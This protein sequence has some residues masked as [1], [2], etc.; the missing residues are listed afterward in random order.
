MNKTDKARKVLTKEREEYLKDMKWLRRE[1]GL[2]PEPQPYVLKTTLLA[3]LAAVE[4]NDA[5]SVDK[6]VAAFKSLHK[7]I[8][9]QVSWNLLEQTKQSIKRLKKTDPELFERKLKEWKAAVWTHT[10]DV[11]RQTFSLFRNC[12]RTVTK[13]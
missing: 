8:M 12:I 6:F 9:Y 13:I 2:I 4:K 11:Y 10:Q 7:S 3:A 5:E 1:Y